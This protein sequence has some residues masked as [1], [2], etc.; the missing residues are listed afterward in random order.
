MANERAKA[1]IEKYINESNSGHFQAGDKVYIHPHYIDHDKHEP[2]TARIHDEEDMM[3]KGIYKV[4]HNGK[5]KS[6][7]HSQLSHTPWG[8]TRGDPTPR[9][10]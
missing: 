8:G 3:S 7:F 5:V 1:L 2:A 9:R 4:V 6:L 10:M